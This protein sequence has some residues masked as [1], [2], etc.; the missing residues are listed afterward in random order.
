[1]EQK[2]IEQIKEVFEIE[3]KEISLTDCFR[4][5]DTW[6]SLT[7]LSLIAM[8]DD[9][10]DILITYSDFKNLFTLSDLFE[11][12]KKKNSTSTLVSY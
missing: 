7:N 6:D 3:G 12:V 10:F 1:M 5:Y 4:D 9:E 8:L 11:L 2:F